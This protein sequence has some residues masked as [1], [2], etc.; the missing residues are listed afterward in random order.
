MEKSGSLTVG[1]LLVQLSAMTNSCS[2]Q[3]LK[4]IFDMYDVDGTGLLSVLVS[5]GSQNVL[6]MFIV[7]TQGTAAWIDK[8]STPSCRQQS[9][10]MPWQS[11]LNRSII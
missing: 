6:K 11:A 7:E 5:D 10:T 2:C 8:S 9:M 1:E 4:L 3:K